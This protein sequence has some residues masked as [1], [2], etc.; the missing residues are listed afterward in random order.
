MVSF[1]DYLNDVAQIG[2]RLQMCETEKKTI[3]LAKY[4][5]VFQKRP[6][7]KLRYF[8]RNNLYLG[9]AILTDSLDY[10]HRM[11]LDKAEDNLSRMSEPEYWSIWSIKKDWI[12]N[13][14]HEGH[15]IKQK[16]GS[17][18]KE[19]VDLQRELL[20]EQSK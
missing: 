9:S 5:L 11:T 1:D 15:I 7:D 19:L 10:A 18:Q 16:I 8:E 14:R 13:K 2:E 12:L 6:S 20:K 3:E 17:L 4:V